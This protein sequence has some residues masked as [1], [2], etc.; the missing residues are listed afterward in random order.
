MG[1]G[2]GGVGERQEVRMPGLVLAEVE[3][4]DAREKPGRRQQR[5][6]AQDAPAAGVSCR[7]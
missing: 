5:E 2:L 4:L 7:R 6:Q 3:E 1:H